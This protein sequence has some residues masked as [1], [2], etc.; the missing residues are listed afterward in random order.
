MSLFQR[1]LSIYTDVTFGGRLNC[2]VYGY[3]LN[4]G[5]SRLKDTSTSLYINVLMYLLLISIR[6]LFILNTCGTCL[7]NIVYTFSSWVSGC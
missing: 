5:V 4:L 1:L 3:A 6:V 2:P 7:I